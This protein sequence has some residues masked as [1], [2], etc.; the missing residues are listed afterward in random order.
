M[1][2]QYL[3]FVMIQNMQSVL[4]LKSLIKRYWHMKICIIL[5]TGIKIPKKVMPSWW[6]LCNGIQLVREP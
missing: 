5:E 6:K 4:I 2:Q 3:L 1:Q